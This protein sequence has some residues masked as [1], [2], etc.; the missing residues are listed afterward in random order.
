VLGVEV[1]GGD[2]NAAGFTMDFFSG[3][4]LLGSIGR[5]V[6]GDGGARI[7]AGESNAPFDL[8]LI[9]DHLTSGDNSFAMA[10]VRYAVAGVHEPLG[11]SF[12][13]RLRVPSRSSPAAEL[14]P[15]AKPLMDWR[16]PCQSKGIGGCSLP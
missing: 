14:P 8:V 11:S 5:T 4:M 15:V 1:E 13:R 12:R 3:S 6:V 9:T 2:F 10:Q 16:Q 7:L